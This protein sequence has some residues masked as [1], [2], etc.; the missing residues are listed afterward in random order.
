MTVLLYSAMFFVD[1]SLDIP[2][3]LFRFSR[4]QVLQIDQNR[5]WSR[6]LDGSDY[7]PGMVFT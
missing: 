4:E 7:L 6:A 2:C 3:K 5:Q 1:S